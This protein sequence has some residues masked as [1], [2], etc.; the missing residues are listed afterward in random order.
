MRTT[1]GMAIAQLLRTVFTQLA[2]LDKAPGDVDA[3]MGA[4]VAH[5]RAFRPESVSPL[6][7]LPPPTEPNTDPRGAP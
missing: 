2:E 7:T 1:R 4:L 3:I 5:A 6:G